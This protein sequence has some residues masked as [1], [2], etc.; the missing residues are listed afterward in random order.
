MKPAFIGIGVQKCATTWVYRILEDHPQACLSSPKELHF[1]SSHFDHGYRWYESHFHPASPAVKV[2]GEYS[3]S[4]FYDLDS[5]IRIKKYNPEARLLVMLRDPIARAFSNHLH[6]VREGHVG[7]DD[8]TFEHH[9][10]SNPLYVE[11]SLYARHLARWREHFSS[12]QILVLLQEDVERDP[13]TQA[14]RVYRFL[15]IDEGHQ[16]L[17]LDVRV[18]VSAVDK[19][20]VTRH[21][22]RTAA[23]VARKTVGDGY[24]R[25]V[26][27]L[28]AMQQLLSSQ[29][30]SLH[31]SIPPMRAET[32]ERLTA[33]FAPDLRDLAQML[34]RDELP[35]PTWRAVASA[36]A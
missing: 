2:A 15:G 27:T 23:R 31:E 5:P 28:P 26:K 16:S 18:N 30:Q 8:V 10:A 22:L 14:A 17:Y 33:L 12:G 25:R 9:E 7:G 11:Q 13:T 32:R 1:F 19:P 21:M 29:R 24:V 35:W 3:T 20:S 34:Q 36:A 6:E 4:Y